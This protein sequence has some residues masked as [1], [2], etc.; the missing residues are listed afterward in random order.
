MNSQHYPKLWHSLASAEA[1]FPELLGENY[2]RILKRIELLWGSKEASDYL[3]SLF[4]G[5]SD[6][7]TDRQ[8]FPVE[9][10]KEVVH[11]KQLHDFLFPE[12][13]ID[14]YDPFSGYAMSAPGR[15][16]AEPAITNNADKVLSPASKTEQISS[17]HMPTANEQSRKKVDWPL[18]HTQRELIEKSEQWRRGINIYP[19]QGLSVEEILMHYGIFD[20]RALRVIQ[21]I[22]KRSASQGKSISQVIVDAG[23]VRNDELLRALCVQA[24]ILMVDIL[25][26]FVPF[27]ALKLVPNS[28]ARE[29]QVMPVG[30]HHDTLFLAVADPFQ[31]TDHQ[32]FALLTGLNIIPVL[33]PRHEIVN[34]LNM[35]K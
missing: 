6:D 21:R 3:D 4:L 15:E 13:S 30:I 2:S 19:V 9:I 26:I 20:E 16:M 7:R 33:A 32:A 11:L 29:K 14:P 8:G 10:M 31:F 12:I 5:D 28:K 34:R 35:Y 1:K 17:A 18:I 24:G 27:K 23:L 25:N 22:Q